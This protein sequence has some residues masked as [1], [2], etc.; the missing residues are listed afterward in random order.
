MLSP[1]EKTKLE[2]QSA[3]SKSLALGLMFTVLPAAGVGS[4]AAIWIGIRGRKKIQ[5]SNGDLVGAGVATW[6][7]YVGALGLVANILFLFMHLR[8]T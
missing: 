5:E 4:I 2:T 8:S 7:I 1:E 3:L 6:C